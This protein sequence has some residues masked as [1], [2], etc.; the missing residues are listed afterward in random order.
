M[1][2]PHRPSRLVVTLIIFLVCFAHL[3]LCNEVAGDLV[4]SQ[5]GE[6]RQ[7]APR[8]VAPLDADEFDLGGDPRLNMTTNDSMAFVSNGSG[9]L[10]VGLI[11]YHHHSGEIVKVSEPHL[12]PAVVLILAALLIWARFRNKT[13][14]ATI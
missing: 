14:S 7:S 9:G 3:V 10:P 8:L 13:D 4:L 2:S 5:T 1:N 11:S 6:E 12:T